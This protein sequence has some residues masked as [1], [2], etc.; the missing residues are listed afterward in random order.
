MEGFN[1]LVINSECLN[2]IIKLNLSDEDF[3]KELKKNESNFI[4]NLTS[5]VDSKPNFE[6]HLKE[7]MDSI[8]I[9]ESIL[10]KID[11]VVYNDIKKALLDSYKLLENILKRKYKLVYEKSF[12]DD[13][14]MLFK[15]Y[16][17]SKESPK[18]IIPDWMNPDNFNSEEYFKKNKLSSFFKDYKSYSFFLD[19]KETL[20][21]DSESLFTEYSFIYR[22]MFEQKF[23]V[24]HVS[25]SDFRIGFL[26]KYFQDINFD[27]F[28][29]LRNA[30]TK[31][32]LIIYNLIRN[33]HVPKWFDFNS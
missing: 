21:S 9:S 30:S 26:E 7:K 18:I 6:L 32:R 20:C 16:N 31:H 28:K 5:I 17:N 10:Q 24:N 19:L 33:K 8:Y 1:Y 29:T 4:D 2:N 15:N 13:F 12:R 23:I 22:K 14:R 11:D 25:E 3:K 27:K